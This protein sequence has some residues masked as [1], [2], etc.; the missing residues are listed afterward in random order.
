M[1]AEGPTQAGQGRTVAQAALHRAHCC[2]KGTKQGENDW[3]SCVPPTA[4][5]CPHPE[6]LGSRV[7]R[8][9]LCLPYKMQSRHTLLLAPHG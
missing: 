8:R 2:Q 9:V 7:L 1:G 6:R 5:F 4:S 3:R